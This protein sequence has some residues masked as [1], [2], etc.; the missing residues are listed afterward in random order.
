MKRKYAG[1]YYSLKKEE[2]GWTWKLFANYFDKEPVQTFLDNVDEDD[3]YL[4][5][6]TAA[7]GVAINA[8]Q[9]HYN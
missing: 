6:E 4:E 8:I 2:K 5:T 1:M 9:D 3:K 7:A